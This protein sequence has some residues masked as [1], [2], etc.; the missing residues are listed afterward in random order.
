MIQFAIILIF[1]RYKC[2]RLSFI[3]PFLDNPNAPLKELCHSKNVTLLCIAFISKNNIPLNSFIIFLALLV[4]GIRLVFFTVG[5][6]ILNFKNYFEKMQI[7]HWFLC[8][9]RCRSKD[10]ITV[11]KNY[12]YLLRENIS[13]IGWWHFFIEKV[14]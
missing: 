6:K 3:L 9:E 1:I 10:R 13:S 11:K 14:S 8:F 7:F 12:Q 5:R 4:I 2:Y